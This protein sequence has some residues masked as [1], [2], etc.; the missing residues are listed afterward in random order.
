[1]FTE[2]R[3]YLRKFLPALSPL[4][5]LHCSHS[6]DPGRPP[7]APQE[8][9]SHGSSCLQHAASFVCAHL[10]RSQPPVLP[11]AILNQLVTG[12]LLAIFH[13]QPTSAIH[14]FG[15][16]ATVSSPVRKAA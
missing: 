11:R 8:P 12:L 15:L 2:Q 4:S 13:S 7:A 5:Q 3:Q 6:K 1:M 16:C 9:R 14:P 10:M